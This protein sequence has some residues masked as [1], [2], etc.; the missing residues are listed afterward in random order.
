MGRKLIAASMGG[1]WGRRLSSKKKNDEILLIVP[2]RSE[3]VTPSLM[4]PARELGLLRPPP[5]TMRA[6]SVKEFVL[7]TERIESAEDELRRPMLAKRWRPETGGV[8]VP[9]LEEPLRDRR[10]P[11]P[12]GVGA[13]NVPPYRRYCSARKVASSR[14][15]GIG[16]FSATASAVGLNGWIVG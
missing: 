7:E 10:P 3:P 11:L 13:A 6:R 8:V 5:E 14:I 12:E 2:V 16:F 9:E 15:A 4:E 1:P